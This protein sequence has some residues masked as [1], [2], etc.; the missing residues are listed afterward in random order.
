V[1]SAKLFLSEPIYAIMLTYFP[2]STT[3]LCFNLLPS[4]LAV[5]RN[6]IDPP[7]AQSQFNEAQRI[8]GNGYILE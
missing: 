1:T 5:T 3:N 4:D 6:L 8:H 2:E 7:L